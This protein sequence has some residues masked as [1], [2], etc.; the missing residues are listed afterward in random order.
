[1]PVLPV[2]LPELGKPEND[3]AP[4]PPPPTCGE[5]KKEICPEL[6]YDF[7]IRQCVYTNWSTCSGFFDYDGEIVVL[8]R[9]KDISLLKFK[10][11]ILL[12]AAE[13][14]P[15]TKLFIGNDILRVGY[16]LYETARIDY[17][18][19]TGMPDSIAVVE[20][21]KGTYRTSVQ[22]VNGDSGGPVF[23]EHK[24]IG[25][26]QALKMTSNNLIVFHMSYVIPMQRFY[27][28]N[29]IAKHLK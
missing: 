28:D 5:D 27:E 7:F 26:M 6:K 11:T 9:E 12:P 10:K 16:G 22:S 1:M 2:P 25:V 29:E 8:N 17:G 14:H 23:H 3:E 21:V 4:V 20:L 24:L 18:K 19:I 15:N 13:I